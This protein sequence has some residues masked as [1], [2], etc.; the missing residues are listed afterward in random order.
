MIADLK[1]AVKK[2]C[3][4][5]LSSVA[6]AQL[7]VYPPG[8][9]VPVADVPALNPGDRVVES[10]T[11]VVVAPDFGTFSDLMEYLAFHSRLFHS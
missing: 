3:E 1:D 4:N 9:Q 2:K 10:A 5:S 7:R 8:T 6:A 11:F